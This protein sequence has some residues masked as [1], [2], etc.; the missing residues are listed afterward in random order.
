MKICLLMTSFLISG[1]EARVG[2]IEWNVIWVG[3]GFKE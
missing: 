1:F 2:C 3:I